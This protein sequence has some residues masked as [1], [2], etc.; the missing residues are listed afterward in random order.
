MGYQ[1]LTEEQVEEVVNRLTKRPAAKKLPDQRSVKTLPQEDID[2][3]VREGGG[4]GRRG[5]A[6]VEGGGA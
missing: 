1:R 3:M 5:K 2:A 6:G 4:R